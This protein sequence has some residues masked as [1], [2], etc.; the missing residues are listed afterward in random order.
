MASFLPASLAQARHVA[1]HGGFAELVTAQAELAVDATC[2]TRQRAAVTLAGGAGITGQLLQLGLCF[3]LFFVRSG[4]A[5]DE[6]LQLR[7]LGGVLLDELG[8]LDVAVDHRGLC[9]G[10]S[11]V[12]SYGTGS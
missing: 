2:A 12:I 10:L 4:G 7:T 3:H 1:T 8:P 6:R 9:H 5:E 11:R